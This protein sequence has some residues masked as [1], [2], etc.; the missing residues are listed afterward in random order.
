VPYENNRIRKIIKTQKDHI[1]KM[2]REILEPAGKKDLE[3]EVYLL[4][5]GALIAS[6][7]QGNSQPVVTAKKILEKIL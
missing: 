5:D 3:D 7:V 4:F 1:K 2:F 6:K